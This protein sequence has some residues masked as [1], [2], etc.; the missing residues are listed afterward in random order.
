M[1]APLRDAMLRLEML[2]HSL[3]SV[4]TC[5]LVGKY[6]AFASCVTVPTYAS[7]F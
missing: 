7:Q 3:G 2:P 1:R 5:L 6:V 4:A